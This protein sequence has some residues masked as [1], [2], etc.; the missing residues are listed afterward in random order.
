MTEPERKLWIPFPAMGFRQRL[1]AAAGVVLGLFLLVSALSFLGAAL[2]RAD[3]AGI[4]DEYL[5]TTLLAEE[6]A[7]QTV[8]VQ[9]ALTD[10]SLTRR[11]DSLKE[12]AGAAAAFHKA[13]AQFRTLAVKDRDNLRSLD[14]L[15][16]DL[17][18]LHDIGRSM[19]GAYQNQGVAE[20][21][22]V[23]E[24]FDRA[25]AAITVDVLKLRD[26]ALPH[27]KCYFAGPV[28][29]LKLL[30]PELAGGANEEAIE[31][32]GSSGSSAGSQGAIS[33]GQWT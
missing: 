14:K 7:F 16:K 21:T 25:A 8:M 31:Q 12:A 11:A 23:M 24:A 32:G 13:E 3:A 28:A 33:A 15:G 17:D 10:A 29:S 4:R 19:V 20:G 26:H 2:T 1:W 30:P 9:Q 18:A 5:P 6:M 22:R 27:L